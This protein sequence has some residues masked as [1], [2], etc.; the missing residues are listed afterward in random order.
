MFAFASRPPLCGALGLCLA[1]LT[2]ASIGTQPAIAG[3]F[4]ISPDA[5]RNLATHI[6]AGKILAIYKREETDRM[7]ARTYYVAEIR[8]EKIEKGAGLQPGQLVYARYFQSEWVG[9][10][11]PPPDAE[12]RFVPTP[13]PK[14]RFRC[15]L[16]D[17]GYDGAGQNTDGG[18]N[19]IFAQGFERLPTFAPR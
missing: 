10:G 14:Q 6:V 9:E 15:Y 5:L 3:K 2:A 18:F 8:L 11:N 16:V 13:R 7:N 12:L 1:I 17:N 19:V 4:P